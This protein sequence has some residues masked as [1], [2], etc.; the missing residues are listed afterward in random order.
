M[1]WRR[2]KIFDFVWQCF[3]SGA[4][5]SHNWSC[6]KDLRKGFYLSQA[7]FWTNYLWKARFYIVNNFSANEMAFSKL[8]SLL[9]VVTLDNIKRALPTSKSPRNHMD[10]CAV[11]VIE[12]YRI[13]S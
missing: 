9:H 12:F 11:F 6:N 10:T 7:S 4:R 8:V 13:K 2:N 5:R 3:K 1:M